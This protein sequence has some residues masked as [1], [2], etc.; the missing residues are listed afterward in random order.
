MR[1]CAR[2]SALERQRRELPK[3]SEDARSYWDGLMRQAGLRGAPP[4]HHLTPYPGKGDEV[5]AAAR[6]NFLTLVFCLM[7]GT[8]ALPHVLTR[9]YTTPSVREARRSVFW[10]LL[11]HP[12][13]VSDGASLCGFCQ[14]RD[15]LESDWLIDR[16][17]TALGQFM[18]QE[19]HGVD[20]GHQRRRYPATR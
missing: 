18:G 17:T 8:A 3:S 1:K 13:A 14:I 15:L 20:R 19:R 6:L 11:F 7:I 16:A 12:R 5:N 2:W 10:S 4:D 9:Y